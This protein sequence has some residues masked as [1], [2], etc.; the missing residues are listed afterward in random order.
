MADIDALVNATTN[1]AEGDVAALRTRI[2][3]RLDGAKERVADAEHEALE[4]AKKAARVT[5][6]YVHD[7]PWMAAGAAGA[8]GLAIGVLIGR[9]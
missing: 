7:H 9:R 8:V 6:D 5:D 1:K 3:E 4:R 2:R